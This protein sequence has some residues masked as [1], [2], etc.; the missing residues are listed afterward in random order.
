[1]IGGRQAGSV[2]VVKGASVEL[3]NIIGENLTLDYKGG[4]IVLSWKLTNLEE[5]AKERANL[6]TQCGPTGCID[7]KPESGVQPLTPKL[8][9]SAL[10]SRATPP[11]DSTWMWKHSGP[12]YS[13]LKNRELESMIEWHLLEGVLRKAKYQVTPEVRIAY[14]R[15]AKARTLR[16]ISNSRSRIPADFIEW[17]DSD[18]I[19]ATTVYGA[20]LD[21][22]GVLCMLRSLELDL[23]KDVVRREYT[24][25]ALAMAVVESSNGATADLSPR[26][27]L[28]L[29]IPEDPRRLVNTHAKDRTLDVNDHIINFLEDHAPIEGD[30]FGGRKG[31]LEFVKGPQGVAI[32]DE[33]KSS[34]GDRKKTMRPLLAADVMQSKPLQDEFNA[35]MAKH[36]QS[37][38]IDCGDQLISPNSGNNIPDPYA[39]GVRKATEIFKAAYEAKG[40]L[41]KNR[42]ASATPAERLAF[43]IRNDSHFP[44]RKDSHRNWGRF[45]VKIAPWPTMTLLVEANHPLRER[46]EIWQRFVDSG[47]AVTYGEYIGGTANYWSM[48]RRLSP[49]PFAYGS[50]QM[51]LKDGGVCGVMANMSVQT[52]TALG[53]PACTAGQPGHCALIVYSFDRETRSY[54]CHGEQYVGAGDDQTVP[55]PNWA[56]GSADGRREMVWFQSV[57]WG[58]NAGFQSYLNS[59][60]ALQIYCNLPKATQK[61]SGLTLLQTGLGLNRYNIA[62]VEAALA[63]GASKDELNKLGTFLKEKLAENRHTTKCPATGLYNV[64]LEKLFAEQGASMDAGDKVEVAAARSASSENTR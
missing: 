55:H 19:V 24:Q 7:G 56:F 28:Q 42:D 25:L 50:F 27:L 22:A 26:P 30:T 3:V 6:V 49:Y 47:N 14:L 32:I 40:R 15:F 58:V 2:K 52:H 5:A 35:Y 13:A 48:S 33:E 41:P 53:T 64:T 8:S 39:D 17:I 59:N 23:G 38:R 20:R 45:P 21:S 34:A 16:E 51:M 43:L 60:I 4:R 29:T 18:P 63:S 11:P 62:L 9:Q 12:N 46:E 1:M 36:G 10:A 54:N 57:A 31:P 37:V 61:T 44:R